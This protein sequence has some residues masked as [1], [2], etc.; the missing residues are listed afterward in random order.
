MRD[1]PIPAVNAAG[2]A[3]LLSRRRARVRAAE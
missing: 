3:F 2:T 1:Q